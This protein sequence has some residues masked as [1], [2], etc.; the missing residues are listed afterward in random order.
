MGLQCTNDSS[1]QRFAYF[2]YQHTT[3]TQC[4]WLDWLKPSHHLTHTE[5]QTLKWTAKC[6]QERPWQDATHRGTQAHTDLELLWQIA[7]LHPAH[8]DSWS[9]LHL[10]SQ[11]LSIYLDVPAVEITWQEHQHVHKYSH[12]STHKCCFCCPLV[13]YEKF[14]HCLWSKEPVLLTFYV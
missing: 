7:W 14:Y 8:L 13:I 10:N 11:H 6:F 12:H 1:K 2:Y 5:H 9:V 3:G 4:I